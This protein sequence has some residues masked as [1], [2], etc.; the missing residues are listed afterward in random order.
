[1]LYSSPNSHVNRALRLLTKSFPPVYDEVLSGDPGSNGAAAKAGSELEYISDPLHFGDGQTDAFQVVA[2]DPASGAILGT[3]PTS[4]SVDFS[5]ELDG[6]TLAAEDLTLD[7][8]PAVDFE[9]LDADSV[10]FDLP[11]G[12]ASGVHIV[13]IEAGAIEAWA[14]GE[15]RG[16]TSDAADGSLDVRLRFWLRGTR[17]RA[18]Y[19]AGRQ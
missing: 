5:F 15:F 3:A 13:R 12:I 7:G 6:D 19:L 4:I 1:M 16:R 8:M 17:R 9:L 11:P 2:T 18:G 10:R 14:G